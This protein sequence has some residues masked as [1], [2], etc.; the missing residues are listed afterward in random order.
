MNTR[1]NAALKFSAL[2]VL[3][4]SFIASVSPAFADSA[5]T[6]SYP[7]TL[8]NSESV[9]QTTVKITAGDGIVLRVLWLRRRHERQW[10]RDFRRWHRSGGGCF[11]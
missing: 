5:S 3:A 8:A 4:M 10:H 9:F 2:A 1:R 7:G 11:F 6:Q